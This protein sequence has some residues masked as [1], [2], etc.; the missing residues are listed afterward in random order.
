MPFTLQE[1]DDDILARLFLV[2][3]ESQAR[4]E[5]FLFGATITSW[6]TQEGTERLFVSS[7]AIMDGSKAIRGGIPVVFPQFGQPNTKLA[8][9][10]FARSSLWTLKDGSVI[11]D[12]ESITVVLILCDSEATRAVWPHRFIL[13]YT[14]MLTKSNLTCTLAA[15][16]TDIA[17]WECH[18]LLHTYFAVPTIEDVR[19]SGFQNRNYQN[20]VKNG[21]VESEGSTMAVVDCE[22]DKV[23]AGSEEAPPMS[24]ITICAMEDPLVT[25]Q[26]SAN[27]GT[28][29]VP[30]DVVFWNA[31]IDKVN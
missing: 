6:K 24:I 14:I 26:T 3:P 9:H 20:K 2:D 22:V 27:L 13:D 12:E 7:Q 28:L 30:H 5:L 29:V 18:T 11:A 25:S 31:W 4:V 17:A 19:V 15:S 1:N 10:G 23:F 8:Q 21:Q 16:N